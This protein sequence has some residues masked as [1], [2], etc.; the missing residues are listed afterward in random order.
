MFNFAKKNT[1]TVTSAKIAGI[2]WFTCQP[3]QKNNTVE[4]ECILDFFGDPS[5]E[6]VKLAA[7]KHFNDVYNTDTVRCELSKIREGKYYCHAF[8]KDTQLA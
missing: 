1:S 2:Q 6:A 5:L 4:S 3:S 7:S 8:R